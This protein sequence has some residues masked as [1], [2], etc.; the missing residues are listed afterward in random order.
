MTVVTEFFKHS[1]FNGASETFVTHTNWRWHWVKFGGTLK[2]EISSLRSN[3]TSGR[4]ANV[5]GFTNNN[6]TGKFASLNVP[7]GHTAWYSSLSNQLNDDIESALIIRRNAREVI[8][9][10]RD[11]IVPDFEVQFDAATAGQQVRRNGSPT[12]SA[13]IFPSHDPNTML[14]RIQQRMIVE[15]DC[16]WDYDATVSFDVEFRLTN[17]TTIDGFCKWVTTWVE[18]GAFSSAIRNEMHPRMLQAA[19]TLT[20]RLRQSLALVNFGAA[21][22]GYR[23]GALY[24]LPGSQPTFPPA[25]PYGRT[26]TS[27][28]D[29]CIVVT[30]ID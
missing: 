2:N 24:V 21:L 16:W 11:M 14:V 18:G 15:L 27:T 28:E 10:L 25:G 23:F 30:R 5:Y 9:P 20:Q 17:A 29:C 26:G 19:G 12:V 7:S 22:L 8:Q 3:V 4:A 1:N 13:L 6:F